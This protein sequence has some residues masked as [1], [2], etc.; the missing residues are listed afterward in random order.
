MTWVPL[1][2]TSAGV[3]SGWKV[4]FFFFFSSGICEQAPPSELRI[5]SRR[6]NC[7]YLA[8]SGNQ[9][10]V[11]VMYRGGFLLGKLKNVVPLPRRWANLKVA[12]FLQRLK[13][14]RKPLPRSCFLQ[15]AVPAAT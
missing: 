15:K 10:T 11:C 9:L 2:G 1:P 7:V 12:C 8:G 6:R 14:W 4:F 5:V 3:S 13:L